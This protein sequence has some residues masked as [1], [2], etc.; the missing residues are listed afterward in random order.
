M[1]TERHIKGLGMLLVFVISFNGLRAA[2]MDIPFSRNATGIKPYSIK[3][4]KY[5]CVGTP[6]QRSSI[7]YCKTIVRRNKPTILNVSVVVPEVLNYIWVK[8]KVFYKFSTYQPFLIDAEQEGCEYIRNRP[9][10]PLADYIYEIV[11]QSVPDLST[12]C[13]HGNRTYNIVWWLE[14]RHTPRS[15]PAGDYRLDVQFVAQD[16]V[17]MFAAETYFSVRR[18]GVIASMLEW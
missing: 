1:M 12:P 16:K 13:P 5:L 9:L 10:I 7:N 11:Q 18:A 2:N 8:V 4:I 14:E 6:Y 3:I 15:I 17:L